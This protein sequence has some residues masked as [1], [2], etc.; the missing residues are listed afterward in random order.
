MADQDSSSSRSVE[1][2]TD[3][4]SQASS[5]STATARAKAADKRARL[6]APKRALSRKQDL[7]ARELRL[8][9]E[10][11][12]ILL[13]TE[14]EAQDAELAAV[15]NEYEDYKHEGVVGSQTT[16]ESVRDWFSP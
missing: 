15:Y 14:L 9:Q 5:T 1:R 7:D 10:R 16:D 8:R 12:W 4:L 13:E 2:F 3:T 11:E 6:L